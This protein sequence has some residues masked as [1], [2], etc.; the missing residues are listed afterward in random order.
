MKPVRNKKFGI[1]DELAKKHKKQLARAQREMGESAK[2][3]SEIYHR[4]TDI[5]LFHKWAYRVGKGWYGFDLG[6]IPRVWVDM[7]GEF[8]TWLETQRPDF[9]IHQIKMKLGSLR[10]Y[11]GTKTD[12]VIPDEK[13]NSEIS[14][15]EALLHTPQSR[16]SLV[17]FMRAAR[18]PR[19]KP[20]R[21]P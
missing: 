15:L 7:I 8:L 3:K 1:V 14:K 10:F 4:F 18:Q 16:R 19:Q 9:E 5:A 12:W 17:A 20:S 21:Q 6:Q 2:K 13:I 11:V